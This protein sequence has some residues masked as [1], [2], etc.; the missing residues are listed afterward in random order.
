[1]VKESH[2]NDWEYF[3][4][5]RHGRSKPRAG[6]LALSQSLQSVHAAPGQAIVF[7]RRLLH[8]GIP[9]IGNRCRVSLEFAIRLADAEKT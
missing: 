1:V 7:H 9:H 6:D 8:A 2:L 5:E 3:V 4:E